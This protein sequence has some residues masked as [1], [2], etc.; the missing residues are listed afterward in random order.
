VSHILI[1]KKASTIHM[2][3]N[4]RRIPS[5][6]FNTELLSWCR[7]QVARTRVSIGLTVNCQ[8]SN[9]QKITVNRQKRNIFIVN[10]Q[11]SK[12]VLASMQMSQISLIK[13]LTTDI[14][15]ISFIILFMKNCF[16]KLF[17]YFPSCSGGTI[18]LHH[19]FTPSLPVRLWE[20]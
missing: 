14:N 11:I 16:F 15:G 8:P 2:M 4:Q 3:K 12:P 18:S 10:R 1:T 20:T 19:S 17:F 7:W 13:N 9:D 5:F 6:H